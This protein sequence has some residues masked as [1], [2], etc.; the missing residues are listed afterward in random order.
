MT[1]LVRF[2]VSV[3]KPLL[4]L[5][6]R[7]L[8]RKHYA[9]RSEALRDMIRQE[10][11]LQAMDEDAEVAGAVTYLFDHHRRTLLNRITDL[12]HDHQELILST[13]HI[14]LDH[15]HCL[16]IVAV[17]GKARKVQQLADRLK[18]V[19]GIAQCLLSVTAVHREHD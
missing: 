4:D 7:H 5:F 1:E 12:Q 6:D 13:Q 11:S 2:G 10:L 18:A 8:Q 15:D 19:K 9:T 3:D 14:H 17:R 16:E